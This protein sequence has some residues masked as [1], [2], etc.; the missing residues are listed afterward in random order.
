MVSLI[1]HPVVTAKYGFFEART[2]A[3]AMSENNTVCD[4]LK[5]RLVA[6]EKLL[7]DPLSDCYIERLLDVVIA[8]VNDSRVAPKTKENEQILSFYNR[9]LNVAAR[10]QSHRRRPS[11]FSLIAS[12]GHGAFGRVQL[13]R[14][15]T[16]GRV[17]AMKVLKKSR[18]LTQH[19]DYW[20]E[21]E[22]M[23]RG[24]SS[25]IVQL[26][27][28]FQDVTSLYMVMEYVP[29]GNLVGWM[30]DVEVISEAACR[31]YAAE[32]VLALSDLHAMG[33]IHRDLKPDNLLLDAG[34]HVKLADFGTAIR[35][36]PVTKLIHCDAAVGTPDYLSPEVLLSQ[37]AGGGSYGFEVDWWALGVLIYEM[38]YGDTPFYSET[39]V[40]TYA[41]I[42]SHANHLKFPE[43]LAVSEA[44][45]DFMKQ[46]LRDRETRL[47]SG[48]DDST[49]VCNHP[50]FSAEW[51]SE[52][53]AAGTL[54][55][56]DLSLVD[57]SWCTIRACR[58]PFQPQ[59]TGETDTAYFQPETDDD[60][61][62]DLDSP[63]PH[64]NQSEPTP[65]KSAD[66]NE[67]SQ[68]LAKFPGVQLAF[69]GFS[70]SSS[71]PDHLALLNGLH[72]APR[73]PNRASTP[74]PSS[75]L[76]N[77][78]HSG[79][80]A[81]DIP[82]L[83]ITVAFAN[84]QRPMV[85]GCTVQSMPDVNKSANGSSN[86]TAVQSQLTQL[87]NQ[88]EDALSLAEMH[89]NEVA[90]LTQQLDK[91]ATR[92]RELETK[93]AQRE[94]AYRMAVEESQQRMEM[95]RSEAA[96]N[97]ARLEAELVKWKAV[98]Q[99]EQTA[100]HSAEAA[101]S[102]AVATA[103]ARLAKRAA[104]VA[105]RVATSGSRGSLTRLTLTSSQPALGPD[106]LDGDSL[107]VTVPSVDEPALDQTIATNL[108]LS[109]IEEMAKR[110]HRAE[111]SAREAADSLEAEQHFCR[112][113]K[114]TSAEKSAQIRELSRE[115][116]ELRELFITSESNCVRY[117]EECEAAR[118]ALAEEQQRSMRYRESARIA[119]E[120]AAS[121]S[122]RAALARR[123]AANLRDSLERM[124]QA[125]E[126]EK[127]KCAV[128]VNKLHEVMSGSNIG[129]LE[130]MYMAS[131][132]QVKDGGGGVG[133]FFLGNTA[134]RHKLASILGNRHQHQISQQN[135][136]I[137]RQLNEIKRLNAE[138]AT[139]RREAQ[140]L[141]ANVIELSRLLEEQRYNTSGQHSRENSDELVAAGAN[142][143][144]V[145]PTG[146]SNPGTVQMRCRTGLFGRGKTTIQ[147]YDS[148]VGFDRVSGSGLKSLMVSESFVPTVPSS[149]NSRDPSTMTVSRQY[150]LGD[151]RLSI[152]ADSLNHISV[153]PYPNSPQTEQPLNDF[154]LSGVLRLGV[155]QQRKKK[156]DWLPRVVKLTTSHLFI[157]DYSPDTV[158]LL[159]PG[160]ST[161]PHVLSSSANMVTTSPLFEIPLTALYH[162]RRIDPSEAIHERTEDL[163]RVFQV[164][165]DR[166]YL[167]CVTVELNATKP[168]TGPS[169][170]LTLPRKLS[171][172][173]SA[174][175]ST[176]N[177]T[178]TTTP[179]AVTGGRRQTSDSNQIVRS[180]L[181]SS[182]GNLDKV[183]T[184]VATP[185]LKIQTIS[186]S[187]F[188]VLAQGHKLQHMRFPRVAYCD[189]C[190]K[191]CWQLVPSVP[192]FQ[193][194]HCQ[195]K[196]HAYH[197][198]T[199]DYVL[200]ACGKAVVSQLFR[201][202][203]EEDKVKW[204]THILA[205]IQFAKRVSTTSPMLNAQSPMAGHRLG[206]QP[207]L[208]ANSASGI[209]VRLTN[210]PPTYSLE[211]TI[212]PEQTSSSTD[213]QP[214]TSSSS[215]SS[216]I[217]EDNP[218]CP[219]F[220][221]VHSSPQ[222]H[223]MVHLIIQSENNPHRPHKRVEDDHR[224]PL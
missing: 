222:R 102:I 142:S 224:V 147:S 26:Y 89:S 136:E 172:G 175:F 20:A 69:A 131:N 164:T 97:L 186:L 107:A 44:G 95:V 214:A 18:M 158:A 213:A 75:P 200:P 109:R 88:L 141:H 215:Q 196:F 34:G 7:S 59:L 58:A 8:A 223:S 145:T 181:S 117:H 35:V 42:M 140:N 207:A 16:T 29:G 61:E 144:R 3:L 124:T 194:L 150:S 130:L 135:R 6:L 24:E 132:A 177:T 123:D 148:G 106:P 25:W 40:N 189:L 112:L 216:V 68:F 66:A 159:D 86:T 155:K 11:D 114:E 77:G 17:C 71:H 12:L 62:Q 201:C 1:Q 174:V 90:E 36:D 179:Q 160:P 64:G 83:D 169:S 103:T 98:A 126:K 55:P 184:N 165:Y 96:T 176:T 138:L 28:A 134:N 121:A 180:V 195:L 116:D 46:L 10:L 156:L 206:S 84:T 157:W 76:L 171:F 92:Y 209:P 133:G 14:E 218:P 125:H 154:T 210:T 191:S 73:A 65:C 120:S 100:R 168:P 67:E 221:A 70:F 212:D 137:K 105:D 57:W 45:L 187:P 110:A 118:R 182:N 87:R 101:G 2:E 205:A 30:E 192:A 56:A 74:V 63:Q 119:D 33:F 188:I 204:I 49:Q 93:F 48:P 170:S 153:D 183:D 203:S 99:S 162:V 4:D 85:D 122:Q 149:P 15:V 143:T 152:L 173:S 72:S 22:I 104:E 146:N 166:S 108:L 47:G 43:G 199:Q 211:A 27:H 60:E 185:S 13:V 202:V 198:E 78:N 31:F 21:R 91:A 127:I 129:A 37:G 115:M 54:H 178:S 81:A 9:F 94:T 163:D 111:A 5:E 219:S 52:Q 151:P 51:A 128:A 217:T 139:S 79:S 113:Y 161:T 167:D 190:R 19:T 82:S 220:L 39:L 197:L 53:K 41:K 50:W 208:G 38:L 23:A 32:T 80:L 193:C